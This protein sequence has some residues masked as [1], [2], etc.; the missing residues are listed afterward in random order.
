[1]DYKITKPFGLG[2]LDYKITDVHRLSHI[3]IKKE[4][5]LHTNYWTL[6]EPLRFMVY[7]NKANEIIVSVPEGTRSDGA[8]VPRP[9]WMLLPKIN[10][11][12]VAAAF[13]HDYLTHNLQ[14]AAK[15]IGDH[16]DPQLFADKLFL[17]A[18]TSDHVNKFAAYAMY[19][20]VRAYSKCNKYQPPKTSH[21]G[22]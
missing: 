1:M 6:Y 17:Y 16:N 7:L 13:L 20:A 22:P 12:Y 15:I 4:W 14:I 11:P 21:E 9:L 3:V 10:A 2:N 5:N 19:V 8:S 18:M